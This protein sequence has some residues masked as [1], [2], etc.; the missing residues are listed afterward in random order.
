MLS[1]PSGITGGASGYGYVWLGSMGFK[2]ESDGELKSSPGLAP[3]P[4]ARRGVSPKRRAGARRDRD[5]LVETGP[6][7]FAEA[8]VAASRG[9]SARRAGVGSGTLYRQFPTR[10]HRIRVAD[11]REVEGPIAAADEPAREWPPDAALDRS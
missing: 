1:E 2:A 5:R 11:R 8:G 3:E 10:E 6:A 7:A 4:R 9:E